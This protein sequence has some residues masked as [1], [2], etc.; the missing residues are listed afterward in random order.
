[1]KP[2]LLL[3]AILMLHACANAPKT[4][5]GDKH[6]EG[7]LLLT[8]VQGYNVASEE[9]TFTFNTEDHKVSGEAGCNHFSAN[10]DRDKN[11][12]SFDSAVSTKKYCEYHQEMENKILSALSEV[13]KFVR[14]GNEYLFYS[15][16]GDLLFTLKK[17]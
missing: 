15:Q 8:S 4:A 11:N 2:L 3:F 13:S 17:Y 7:E 12:I 10:Y 14:D 1:M 16:K 6:P 9:L 5:S